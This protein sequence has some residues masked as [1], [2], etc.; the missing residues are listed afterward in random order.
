MRGNITFIR[1]KHESDFTRISN[2]LLWDPRLS[3]KAKGLGCVILRLPDDWYLHK[4]ELQTHSADGRNATDSGLNE[5]IENG[6]LEITID[7]S[8]TRH[9]KFKECPEEAVSLYRQR[10]AIAQ[11]QQYADYNVENMH[12]QCTNSTDNSAQNQHL[13]TTEPTTN[14]LT[15]TK[16]VVGFN[17]ELKK[18]IEEA[19]GLTFSNDFYEELEKTCSERQI[20][21][22]E[23]FDWLVKTK[24]PVANQLDAYIYK[25]AANPNVVNEFLRS[26]KEITKSIEL[27]KQEEVICPECKHRFQNIDFITRKCECGLSLNEIMTRKGGCNE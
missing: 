5:L 27:Q 20:V 4:C 9:Y 18:S 1:D 13:L 19:Y 10:K 17:L 16:S 8:G 7:S 3:L 21:A 23:Y 26:K 6:Y 22:E 11:N 2:S 14:I 25:A 15:T 24:G 12:R